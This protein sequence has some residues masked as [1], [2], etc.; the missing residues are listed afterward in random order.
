MTDESPKILWDPLAMG[1]RNGILIRIRK[2]HIRIRNKFDCVEGVTP[3]Y[4]LALL[5]T[6]GSLLALLT[7]GYLLALL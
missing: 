6:P 5:H 1:L 4:L 2:K 7:P 3:D